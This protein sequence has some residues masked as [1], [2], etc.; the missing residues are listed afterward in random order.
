MLLPWPFVTT[1]R[2][3][4]DKFSVLVPFKA[5]SA[6]TF[7]SLGAD[8]IVMTPIAQLSPVEPTVK[9][10]FSPGDPANPGNKLG[11]NVEDVSAFFEFTGDRAGIE[12]ESGKVSALSELTREV[13]AIALGHVYRFHKLARL[14]TEKLLG[15]HMDTQNE[16]PEIKEIVE[17]VVSRLFAH[18]YRIGR[19]EARELGLK[20]IDATPEEDA[21]IWSLFEAYEESM[22]LRSP[23]LPS[24]DIFPAGDTRAEM[25]DVK[26]VYVESTVQTDVFVSDFE[27]T[28]AHAQT[29]PGQPQ[30]FG[31]QV[32]MTIMRQAWETE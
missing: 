26:L 28:R 10:P 17:N 20:A 6:A 24:H 19:D 9:M 27:F 13:H 15:L 4:F 25:K 30:R 18:E 1:L 29:P 14:Q 11:I 5:H 16:Q 3:L 2:R 23:L 22:E 12:S 7:I 21:A 32:Q 8:E 31:P